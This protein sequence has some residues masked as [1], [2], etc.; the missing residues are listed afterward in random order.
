[1]PSGPSIIAAPGSRGPG[2]LVPTTR[3]STVGP[4]GTSSSSRSTISRTATTPSDRPSRPDQPM[5]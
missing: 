3:A 1:M 2:P 5:L 4:R